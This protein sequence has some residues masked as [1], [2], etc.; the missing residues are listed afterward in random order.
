MLHKGRTIFKLSDDT[1]H[2]NLWRVTTSKT[3]RRCLQ[4]D[5]INILQPHQH[6]STKAHQHISTSPK[7][8][9]LVIIGDRNTEEA[10]ACRKK[11]SLPGIE[12]K[13]KLVDLPKGLQIPPIKHWFILFFCKGLTLSIW[14]NTKRGEWYVKAGQSTHM[15][16]SCLTSGGKRGAVLLEPCGEQSCHKA[17]TSLHISTWLCPCSFFFLPLKLWT[18]QMKVI[19]AS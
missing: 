6:I 17:L 5:A 13:P 9:T 18:F 16:E 10:N 2:E 1:W 3:T 12:V 15:Q 14:S 11:T 7:T 8:H 19:N 4:S